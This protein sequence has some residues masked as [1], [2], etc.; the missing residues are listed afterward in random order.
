M[1][2]NLHQTYLYILTLLGFHLSCIYKKKSV[3]PNLDFKY[4][5]KKKNFSSYEFVSKLSILINFEKII[6]LPP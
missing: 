3:I 1:S 5:L 4:K 2:K 6:R